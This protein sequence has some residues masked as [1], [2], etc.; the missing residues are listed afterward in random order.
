VTLCGVAVASIVS[1]SGT[2]V[3]VVAGSAAGPVLGDVVVYST[4]RGVT[5]ASNAYAYF[6]PVGQIQCFLLP[7]SA[8]GA[9]WRVTSG[10][11]TNWH[12]TGQVSGA[13]PTSGAPYAVT[14]STLSGWVTPADITGI[15]PVANGT[16]TVTAVYVPQAMAL[17]PGT[18]FLMGQYQGQGGHGVTLSRFY[19]DRRP[20][21]VG[22]FQAFCADTGAAMPSPPAW[23]W[24]NASL[25]MVNVTW[26]EAAAY[27]AWAGKRLP[28]EAEYECAMRDTLANKLYPWGDAIGPANANYLNLW[29]RPTTAGTYAATA[30]YGLWDI[31][32]NVWE[33]CNDWY[34]D[35]LTG[36]VTNPAG[37]ASGTIKT[38]RGGSW[39]NSEVKLRCAGRYQMQPGVRYADLGFRCAMDIKGA[40]VPAGGGDP[41]RDSD[42]DGV[43]D[44]LEYLAG[45]DPNDASSWLGIESVRATGAGMWVGWKGGM[46]ATQYLEATETLS[47]GNWRVLFTN[48]PPT[49][50]TTNF[51]DSAATNRTLFYR[52]KAG[53]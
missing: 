42:G 2:Q 6:E 15:V 22:E 49:A 13:A 1:Q 33:W 32:G 48:V 11:D 46:T 27:A 52:I 30:N 25:P 20:V 29:G 43:P 53:R 41:N 28:T 9:Q 39:V 38:V 34:A 40:G 45:T 31:A 5:V 26:S 16:A 17:I 4:V 10:P 18:T 12:S 3:V 21:T 7:G 37:P 24:T 19:L 44:A 23:G 51:V 14:F 36:P 8:S 47:E 35:V 50:T